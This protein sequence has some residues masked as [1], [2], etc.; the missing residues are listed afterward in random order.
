MRLADVAVVGGGPAG[1]SCA[2]A[3]VSA[4]FDVVVLDKA[5]FPRTKLCAGWVTPE[6]LADLELDP[7]DYPHRF[8]TFD[9]LVLHWKWLS[10]RHSSK[11]HSIRRYEFDDFLLQRST[12]EIAVHK[13]RE[14][15]RDGMDYVIDGAFRCRYLVGAGGTSC[16]VYRTF[17]HDLNPRARELQTATLELEYP[18]DW[19]VADC[20]L[21]FF[22]DGLPGY[23]WYVPKQDG[24]INIGIG[25]MATRL[26][27]GERQLAQYWDLFV[28]HL[29]ERNFI[30]DRP[31]DPKGYSYYVRG[32]VDVIRIDNACIIGDAVGLATRDMCEGIG[33]AIQSGIRAAKAIAGDSEFSLQDLKPYSGSGV[34]S[35]WLERGFIGS[36][37]Q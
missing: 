37:Q 17:F 13:V 8:L 9:K 14:I 4:G 18:C 29:Q 1:S 26:K 15:E 21:W 31:L 6:A 10:Y 34:V 32:N 36:P 24:F 35:R 28:R 33:P 12:A 19:K 25:G 20:H 11:Q 23:A 16:P 5:S 27:A 2:R 7:S 3:L 30:D 22:M